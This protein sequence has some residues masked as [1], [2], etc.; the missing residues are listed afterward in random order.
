M[1]ANL[2]GTKGK[3][4]SIANSS[5]TRLI[6][7]GNLDLVFTLRLSDNFLFRESNYIRRLGI[8]S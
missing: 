7:L 1:K 6:C 5:I 2:N 3:L 8:Y 4:K